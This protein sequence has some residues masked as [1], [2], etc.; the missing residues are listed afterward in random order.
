[1]YS[2]VVNTSVVKTLFSAVV[3][4]TVPKTA[5]L[6]V[7]GVTVAKNDWAVVDVGNVV[8]TAYQTAVDIVIAKT[9]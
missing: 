3:D 5:Y 9:V 1:M 6:A 2:T 4:V 8:G 7:V